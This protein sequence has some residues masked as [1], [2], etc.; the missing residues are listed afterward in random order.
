VSETR[1]ITP[2]PKEPAGTAQMVASFAPVSTGA[3][4]VSVEEGYKLWA[5]TYDC[6]PNPLLA[7]EAR[8]LLPRLAC[9]RGKSVL[10]VACGTG[11][12]L[13]R[14]VSLGANCAVGIDLSPSML[15]VAAAKP[16]V[17]GRLARADCGSLPCRSGFADLILCSFALSHIADAM[18]F[19][20]EL[21]RVANAGADV[22]VSDLHPDAYERGWRTRFHS[23]DGKTEIAGVVRPLNEVRDVLES[24]GLRLVEFEEP[25]L[26]DAEK[27]IFAARGRARLF[28]E[29]AASP[30][31]LI[32]RFARSAD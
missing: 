29:A 22:F 21:A 7:L 2:E 16:L 6:D 19:A 20:R 31:V 14:F 17:K 3:R 12:W 5:P 27:P 25:H 15:E 10:D 11:R 18:A 28:D 26:G 1:S 23:K 32:C 8:W 24:H 9:C 30:A 13:E 4:R